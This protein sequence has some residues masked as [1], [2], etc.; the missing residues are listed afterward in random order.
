M[1]RFFLVCLGGAVGTGARYALGNFVIALAGTGTF[2]WHTFAVNVIGSFAMSFLGHVA[3]ATSLLSPTTRAVL[4]TGVLG[5]FTTYSSF[6]YETL[7]LFEQGAWMYGTL[8]VLG[9]VGA[10]V[11]AGLFGAAAARLAVGP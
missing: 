3:L 8:N 11:V 1:Q 4:A 7:G 5:G 2:P 10:C 9:T 6:N